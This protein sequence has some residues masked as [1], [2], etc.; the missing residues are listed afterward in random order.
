VTG[1]ETVGAEGFGVLQ[2]ITEFD[3]S[4][5]Q[6]VGVGGQPCGV[7]LD[8]RREDRVPVLLDKV[9]PDECACDV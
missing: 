9:N 7:L 4:I 2:E 6:D 8:E 3:E 5:A 1:S